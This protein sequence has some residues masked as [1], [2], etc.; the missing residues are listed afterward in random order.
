MTSKFKHESD[1]VKVEMLDKWA[2]VT[3]I[4]QLDEA[5]D[6]LVRLCSSVRPFDYGPANIKGVL[7]KH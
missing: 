1:G 3:T 2:D 6:N 7:S 5:L 4:G